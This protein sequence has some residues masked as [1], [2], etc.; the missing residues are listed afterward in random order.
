MAPFG[1]VG[2]AGIEP[3]AMLSALVRL[4]H[5]VSPVQYPHIDRGGVPPRIV[6]L[7]EEPK[8]LSPRSVSSRVSVSSS[9]GMRQ[10]TITN[11]AILSPAFTW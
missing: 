7:P 11:W 1:V 10:G 2:I 5:A 9:V 6:Y 8:P 4:L 3:A